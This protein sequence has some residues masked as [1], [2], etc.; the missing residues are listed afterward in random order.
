MIVVANAV[1]DKSGSLSKHSLRADDDRFISG[2]SD[3]S[4]MIKH[5]GVAAVLQINHGGRFARG[6][7]LYAP[8]SVTINDINLGGNSNR[9][10]YYYG[11][12][13]QRVRQH[14][15]LPQ[16]RHE[17]MYH[18]I[19]SQRNYYDY[20]RQHLNNTVQLV[21]PQDILNTYS[22]W[23]ECRSAQLVLT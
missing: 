20:G 21:P 4:E 10:R 5:E 22:P 23:M 9:P 11:R 18:F 16:L 13:I 6:E 17:G 12:I 8:S 7:T 15:Q 1:V 2:L 3:L 19:N 14:R